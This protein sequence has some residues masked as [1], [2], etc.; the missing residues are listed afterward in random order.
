MSTVLLAMCPNGQLW[1]LGLRA[2]DKRRKRLQQRGEISKLSPFDYSA[3]RTEMF[4]GVEV[5]GRD[6]VT[7]GT[8]TSL[9]EY[10]VHVRVVGRGPKR[11]RHCL[12]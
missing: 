8:S 11:K 5:Y 9:M 7:L 2:R 4:C 3:P 6:D 10:P 12:Q 1:P